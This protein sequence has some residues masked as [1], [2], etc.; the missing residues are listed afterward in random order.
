MK[1]I[2]KTY[3]GIDFSKEKFNACILSS[4]G[5]VA[6]EYVF[7]NVRKG[8]AGLVS[9]VRSIVS[10]GKRDDL[11]GKVLFCGEHTGTCSIG[12]SEYL[13]DKGFDMWLECAL[14]IKY[15]SGVSREKNDKADARMI[16]NYARRFYAEGETRL[17]KPETEDLKALR[18]L[19]GL[20][21]RLVRNRV[22]LGNQKGSM[23]FDDSKFARSMTRKLYNEG[24]KRE[25]LVQEEMVRLMTTSAELSAN[26]TILTSFKG[27]GPITAAVLIIATSNFTAFTDPRK[28]ACHC[29]IAPFGKQSGTSVNGRPHVSRFADTGIK[30]ALVQTAKSAMQFNPKIRDYAA[31]LRSKG[32]HEGI[33]VNNVKNKIIHIIFKM[34]E[35]KTEWNPDH[36]QYMEIKRELK[37]SQ[38]GRQEEKT[39]K[40]RM[41]GNA[42]RPYAYIGKNDMPVWTFEEKERVGNKKLVEILAS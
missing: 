16:A 22:A 4:D 18:S 26:Y 3:I 42:E 24:L 33:V 21:S 14:N 31:R 5:K 29:G 19:Y 37:D 1:E 17:F 27:I 23:A 8:Y 32:K 36:E 13:Y 39:G 35:T 2:E 34:I 28:F 10:S 38:E 9:R 12:L 6:G 30:A 15:S 7:P 25:K 11:R 20:R 41:S 40:M